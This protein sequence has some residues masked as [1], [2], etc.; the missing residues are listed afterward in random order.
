MMKT[1]EEHDKTKGSVCKKQQHIFAWLDRP[2]L[3]ILV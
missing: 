3:E 2:K 1:L